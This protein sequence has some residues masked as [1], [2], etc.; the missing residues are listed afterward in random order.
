MNNFKNTLLTCQNC[1]KLIM[2]K[3]SDWSNGKIQ[4]SHID[5]GY[6]NILCS[7]YCY[8]ENITQ[9]L[10]EFGKLVYKNDPSYEYF[11]KLG[12]NVIGVAD[13]CDVKLERFIHNNKCFISRRHST[14]EVIF[15]KWN[16]LFRYRI[17]DGAD[18]TIS[19]E[20][21]RSLNG[22]KINDL[23]LKENEIVDIPNKG[24]INIGGMDIFEV[25]PY[26]IP[27]KVLFSHKIN[28]TFDEDST[29]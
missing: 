18:D 23:L 6:V 10:S 25:S 8:S 5:C 29:Q 24:T 27:E 26:I 15:D 2:V 12:K 16:G 21:K 19:N 17:S 3:A 7:H 11:L 4:C 28:V 1:K 9:N 22:T 13:D 14:I 20:I